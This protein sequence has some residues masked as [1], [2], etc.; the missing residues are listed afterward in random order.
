MQHSERLQQ[1]VFGALHH[2]QP[3]L[4]FVLECSE[5][6]KE[7]SEMLQPEMTLATIKIKLNK[8]NQGENKSDL[9]REDVTS[10]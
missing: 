6:A 1:L 4:S 10:G 5:E 8:Q 2:S 3:G 7:R 9:R